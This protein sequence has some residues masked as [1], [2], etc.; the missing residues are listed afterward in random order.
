MN[1]RINGTSS[2]RSIFAREAARRL[3][4][5]PASSPVTAA[6]L[7]HLPPALQKYLDRCRVVG[8]ARVENFHARFRGEMRRSPDAAWMPI[9]AEQYSF[10]PEPAR[11]F[12][13]HATLLGIPFDALHLYLGPE[14]SMQVK[15]AS[16]FRVVDARGPEMNQGETVTMFNDM[17]LMAPATLIDPSIGWQELDERIVKGTFTNAGNTI[18]ATL[19]F[20]EAGDLVNF[21]S[22]DRYLSADGKKYEKF[23]WSTPIDEY[24]VFDDRRV[25]SRATAR[26]Q[27]PDGELVYGRFEVVGIDYNVGPA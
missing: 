8:R 23:R 7:A 24:R 10:V 4:R 18:S 12:L 16:L 20:D 25:V 21:V 5:V 15:V 17:C 9:E 1:Q 27:L 6:D 19:S 26:W 11:L 3:V 13:M 14:A 22:D 2:F